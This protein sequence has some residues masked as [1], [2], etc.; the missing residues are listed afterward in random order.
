[1]RSIY[2]LQFE[3]AQRNTYLNRLK[4]RILVR[5]KQLIKEELVQ[6]A[7]AQLPNKI[8]REFLAQ[9]G[10]LISTIKNASSRAELVKAYARIDRMRE[11]TEKSLVVRDLKKLVK[12]ATESS[13]VS[14]D[15]RTWISE[16]MDGIDFVKH[17]APTMERIQ[18]M[19]DY[20]DTSMN[21][22]VDVTVTNEM[23]KELEMLA[24][25]GPDKFTLNDLKNLYSKIETL[26]NL[27]RAK[28]ATYESVQQAIVDKMVAE[29]VPSMKPI[30]RA[31]I[32]TLPQNLEKGV[33]TRRQKFANWFKNL[34]N[35]NRNLN[36][37]IMPMDYIADAL[38]GGYGLFDG[39]VVRWIRDDMALSYDSFLKK[40]HAIQ[41]MIDERV[42][43]LGLGEGNLT[44]ITIKMQSRTETGMKKIVSMYTRHIPEGE[45]S[46]AKLGTT[47]DPDIAKMRMT[48]KERAKIQWARRFTALKLKPNEEEFVKFADEQLNAERPVLIRLA[49]DVYNKKFDV[50]E[51]MFPMI[52]DHDAMA[53]RGYKVEDMFGDSAYL[54]GQDAP[55]TVASEVSHKRTTV[56]P[57][58]IRSRT[59]DESQ[60]IQVNASR[61]LMQHLENT[62]Y[63]EFMAEKIKRMSKAVNSDEFQAA[64]GDIG[65]E[66]MKE[67]ADQ[68]ARKGG[69]AGQDSWP[70]LMM[71]TRNASKAQLFAKASTAAVQPLAILNTIGAL[72]PKSVMPI[73][74]AVNKISTSR[75]AREYVYKNFPQI[76]ER[77]GDDP[78]FMVPT[79][80]RSLDVL[81]RTAGYPMKKSDSLTAA[82]GALGAYKI[83]L[84][85]AGLKF[86][87]GEVH[88]E[89]VVRAER[90]V[91]T[92]QASSFWKDLPP[93]TATGR[94]LTGVRALNKVMAM[95][96]TFALTDWAQIVHLG[97]KRM[98]FG[99]TVADK[100]K[101]L[102]SIM[103]F[104]ATTGALTGITQAVY[105]LENYLS[106][107]DPNKDKRIIHNGEEF[108]QQ[109]LMQ[110]LFKVP[111]L[112]NIVATALFDS[113]SP[114]PL[115]NTFNMGIKGT[116]Q[117]VTG[118]TP[119]SQEKGVVKA[120][121][122]V[123]SFGGVGGTVQAVKL[124]NLGL[125]STAESTPSQIPGVPPVPAIP[126]VPA[127]IPPPNL[128]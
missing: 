124:L 76:R 3:Q 111:F 5:E 61:V 95:F 47:L 120:V 112:S 55:Q 18:K 35:K 41:D 56:Q 27:G 69:V 70:I 42:K 82:A 75:M 26:Y 125:G 103:V 92:T 40:R 33:I 32:D 93:L 127:Q 97:V 91:S 34:R 102:W 79:G 80:L 52:T 128:P 73:M 11:T 85:K 43:S 100:A 62:A 126:P 65:S 13:S 71:L 110:M 17:Q 44:R 123:L 90:A 37:A 1:L 4:E 24:A 9:R 96:Q 113:D 116:Y 20:I 88:P 39:P 54:L 89:I 36:T 78:D 10:K 49:R 25:V 53:A 16:M 8:D 64:A 81:N 19:R 23:Q 84:R 121:G 45:V 72:G 66:I 15:Y 101:G 106:G 2:E 122:T 108:T 48:P 86:S 58:T 60:F 68:Y 83:E 107:S 105:Y 119:E 51:D 59:G 28:R 7:K 46:N 63:M 22:G 77:I 29:M 50:L 114:I 104:L 87:W 21:A 12:K 117:A 67:H 57:G 99:K 14:A 109:Y 115:A 31:V 38:D 6:Y 74:W 30:S 118:A 94:S 98:F